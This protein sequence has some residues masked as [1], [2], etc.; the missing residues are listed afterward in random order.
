M[1][2]RVVSYSVR[3]CRQALIDRET[4]RE[5]ERH[6][7]QE[8]KGRTIEHNTYRHL[9]IRKLGWQRLPLHHT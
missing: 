7:K 3:E 1:M 8:K 4:E 2:V 5:T 9:A 6:N